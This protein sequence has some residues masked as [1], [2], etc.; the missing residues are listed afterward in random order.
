[1]SLKQG[2]IKQL[3]PIAYQINNFVGMTLYG[4]VG[5][6]IVRRL[7]IQTCGQDD[8]ERHGGLYA[9]LKKQPFINRD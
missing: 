8:V 5:C 2:M 7:H 4:L 9:S 3:K 6:I 1:M